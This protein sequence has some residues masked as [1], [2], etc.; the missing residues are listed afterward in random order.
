MWRLILHSS[1]WNQGLL[2]LV[3]SIVPSTN[4]ASVLEG[5]QGFIP[6]ECFAIAGILCR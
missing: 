3:L 5:L 4:L 2:L 1:R 6:S